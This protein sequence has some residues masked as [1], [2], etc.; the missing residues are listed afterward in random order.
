M[1]VTLKDKSRPFTE[2][3]KE[4]YEQAFGKK[5]NI[6]TLGISI[7]PVLDA[8]LRENFDFFAKI[9]YKMFPEMEDEFNPHDYKEHQIIHLQ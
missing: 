6:M 8:K 1:L 2:D 4:W 3:E 9:H 5:R 7:G